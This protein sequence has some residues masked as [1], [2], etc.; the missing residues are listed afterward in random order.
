MASPDWDVC[1]SPAL[2]YGR[3]RVKKSLYVC[4][5][6]AMNVMDDASDCGTQFYIHP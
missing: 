3:N 2:N 6:S 5:Y 1:E 4:S